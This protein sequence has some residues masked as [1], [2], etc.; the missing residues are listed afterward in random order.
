M[1]VLYLCMGKDKYWNEVGIACIGLRHT[2][3]IVIATYTLASSDMKN[4]KA[5]H[6]YQTT[7]YI[8]TKHSK[9]NQIVSQCP[10][11]SNE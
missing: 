10:R 6:Q 3:S 5:V 1:Y 4:Y 9:I 7:W 2:N 8:V 11:P